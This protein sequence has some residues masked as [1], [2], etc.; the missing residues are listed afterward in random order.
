MIYISGIKTVAN[1]A[2]QYNNLCMKLCYELIE[3]GKRAISKV[4]AALNFLFRG[5]ILSCFESSSNISEHGMQPL[6][7]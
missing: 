7:K 2:V 5:N 6:C 1:G 4:F 3:L